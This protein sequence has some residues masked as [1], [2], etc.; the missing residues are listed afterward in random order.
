MSTLVAALV[1]CSAVI[2]HP[3]EITTPEALPF[4][5]FFSVASI[6]T[7]DLLISGGTGQLWPALAVPL[8][9]SAAITTKVIALEYTQ[10]ENLI[11]SA[12]L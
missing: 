5:L 6:R 7:I 12:L 8:K 9:A 10:S 1:T 3:L 2:T 4:W 11:K